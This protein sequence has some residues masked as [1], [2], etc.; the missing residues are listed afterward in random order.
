M[1]AGLKI[2]KG[3]PASPDAFQTIPDRRTKG[4]L[5]MA[6]EDSARDNHW[7]HLYVKPD[8][9]KRIKQRLSTAASSARL[10]LVMQV[11]ENTERAPLVCL[12]FLGGPK[13]LRPVISLPAPGELGPGVAP[14][15]A[16]VPV[17]GE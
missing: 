17:D 14:G 10:R 4:M 8:E 1:D 7:R 3:Q 13:P 12:R 2:Y 15:S 9:V 5:R 11:I 16:Q 6:L